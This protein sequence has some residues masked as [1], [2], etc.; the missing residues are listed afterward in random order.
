MHLRVGEVL[1]AL[2]YWP[3]SL[4]MTILAMAA[5]VLAI[6]CVILLPI[7][8][9]SLSVDLCDAAFRFFGF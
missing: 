6:P 4:A 8:V 9:V 3:A 2:I 1:L 5:I 7:V